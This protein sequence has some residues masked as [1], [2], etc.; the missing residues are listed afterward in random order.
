MFA[1]EHTSVPCSPVCA[2]GFTKEA[3]HE[4]DRADVPIRLLDLDPFARTYVEVYDKVNDN[5]RAILHPYPDV[6]AKDGVR[7]RQQLRKTINLSDPS[8]F[9]RENSE[10]FPLLLAAA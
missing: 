9:N 7:K 2:G 6:S 10:R 5:D 8:R 3:G 4:A 1:R